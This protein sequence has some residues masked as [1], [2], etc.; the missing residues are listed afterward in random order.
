MTTLYRFYPAQSRFTVHAVATGVLSFAAHSPTFAVREFS[1]EARMNGRQIDEL[2]LLLSTRSLELQ[3]RVAPAD[4][5]EIEGRMRN[6]VLET[7]RYPEVRFHAEGIGLEPRSRGE[8]QASIDS[9]LTLHGICRSYKLLADVVV[10]DDALRLRGQHA[11]RMSQHQ[12]KPVTHMGGTIKL[13]DELDLS[14]DIVGFPEK[15]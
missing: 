9:R 1:G 11:L 13:K 10:Y 2:S 5:R 8:Y 14:F 12:I 4:R 7:N 3:D 6:E 15:S